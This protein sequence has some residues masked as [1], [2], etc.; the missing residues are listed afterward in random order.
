M[1]EKRQKANWAGLEPQAL[2]KHRT[3]QPPSPTSPPP[4]QRQN[5]GLVNRSHADFPH[6][7]SSLCVPRLYLRRGK[8]GGKEECRCYRLFSRIC[9]AWARVVP[10]WKGGEVWSLWRA[11]RHR[12]QCL[13]TVN[14]W[15][16]LPRGAAFIALNFN[17]ERNLGIIF[18]NPKVPEFINFQQIWFI[19]C[20]KTCTTHVRLKSYQVSFRTTMEWN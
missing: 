18:S 11:A 12:K 19:S 9:S 15:W 3:K 2:W 16:R 8:S 4:P 17:Q 1:Q 14:A 5:P 7:P 20:L 13:C 10:V 6:T